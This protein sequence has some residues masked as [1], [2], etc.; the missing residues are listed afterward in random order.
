MSFRDL[1]TGL[2]LFVLAGCGRS[3]EIK[4]AAYAPL[5]RVE[6]ATDKLFHDGAKTTILGTIYV[7][8]LDVFIERYPEGS[9]QRDALFRH[10]Q[11][12]STRQWTYP[13]TPGL[14]LVRYGIDSDFRWEEEKAGWEQEIKVLVKAGEGVDIDR[15]ARAMNENYRSPAGGRMVSFEDALAWVRA[16]V[17][18]ASRAP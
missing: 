12:H 14:W 7:T 16:T 3:F 13:G 4:D 1:T 9:V 5:V 18:A 11:V 6:E 2:L 8:D 10:E 15:V 17:D